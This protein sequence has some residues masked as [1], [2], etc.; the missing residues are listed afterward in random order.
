MISEAVRM[1]ECAVANEKRPHLIKND[2]RLCSSFAMALLYYRVFIFSFGIEVRLLSSM[3]RKEEE[4]ERGLD[5]E[6]IFFSHEV[7]GIFIELTS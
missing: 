6:I 4:L 2:C 1:F 3:L 5:F 7:N